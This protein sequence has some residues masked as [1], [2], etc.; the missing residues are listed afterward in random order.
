M[1]G[2]AV[3]AA[4]LALVACQGDGSQGDHASAKVDLTRRIVAQYADQ[5]YPMWA[6][7]SPSA[8]CPSSLADL[9]R[10]T[11]QESPRDA[12]ERDLVM[13]C[14]AD[15]PAEAKGFGVISTGA[16]GKRDTADDIR[17]WESGR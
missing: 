7:E 16:D 4:A 9:A 5:A 17:S 12:W 3:L 6:R 2:A 13:V 8:Q 15:A 11:N 1:G 14:G 10:F